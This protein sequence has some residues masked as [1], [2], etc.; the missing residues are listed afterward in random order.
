[1]PGIAC[2]NPVEVKKLIKRG[3]RA[4]WYVADICLLWQKANEQIKALGSDFR[5]LTKE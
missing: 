2:G 1:M 5:K 3:F 4:F